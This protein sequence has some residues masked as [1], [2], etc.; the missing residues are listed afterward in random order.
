MIKREFESIHHRGARDG[1][2][3][4]HALARHRA[5]K[6]QSEMQ[7]VG[8]DRAPLAGNAQCQRMTM[9]RGAQGVVRPQ[10][11]KQPRLRVAG[12][13]LTRE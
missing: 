10:R 3:F 12:Q 2:K 8:A 6:N 1:I 9:Q 7:F 4:G 11:E 5:E 13:S